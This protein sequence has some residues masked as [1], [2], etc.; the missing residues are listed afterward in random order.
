MA[1]IFPGMDPS[2][3]VVSLTNPFPEIIAKKWSPSCTQESE[4]ALIVRALEP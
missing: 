1:T 2:A 4:D 3:P